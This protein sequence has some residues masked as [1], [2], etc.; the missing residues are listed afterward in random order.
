MRC[1]VMRSNVSI[2]LYHDSTQ[3]QIFS[4]YHS[5]LSF[6]LFEN[7]SLLSLPLFFTHPTTHLH[8]TTTSPSFLF[9]HLPYLLSPLLSLLTS[10]LSYFLPSPSLL[11]HHSLL[12]PF[13]VAKEWSFFP[14]SS[15]PM[16]AVL[17]GYGQ[18]CERFS[19]S[20]FKLLLF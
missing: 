7:F 17:R 12:L 9:K 4:F 5:I 3:A 8:K 13:S 14:L 18:Y 6:S 19:Y 15:P 16:L 20:S 10:S 2:S 11:L 1:I